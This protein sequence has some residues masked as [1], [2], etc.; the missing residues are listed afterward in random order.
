MDFSFQGLEEAARATD[1]IYE[2]L[3]RV[4]RVGRVPQ[5]I[6]PD[7]RSLDAF[8]QE[9]DDDFN[10]PKALALIFDE[11][12]TINRL[13]D[14]KRTAEIHARSSALRAMGEVLGLLQD[15]P[16][17]FFKRKKDRWLQQQKL[18]H[19]QIEAWIAQRNQA[20]KE[21]RWQ[22]AD[23]IRQELLDR[24]IVIEDMPGGTLWKVK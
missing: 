18:T 6:E 22:E 3:E 20:R 13:L 9:M 19:E 15:A 12:R 1:R 10:T 4:E 23:H 16:E 5:N 24:G 8:R 14:D 21:K 11:V 17:V 7:R 2:T